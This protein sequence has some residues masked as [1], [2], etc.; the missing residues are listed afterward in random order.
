MNCKKKIFEAVLTEIRKHTTLSQ[1]GLI[2]KS[3]K[4]KESEFCKASR[5]KLTVSC[6]ILGY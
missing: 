1:Y 6:G 2:Q 4:L 5:N 3:L